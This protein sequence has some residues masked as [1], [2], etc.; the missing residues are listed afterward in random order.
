[1]EKL[2]MTISSSKTSFPIPPKFTIPDQLNLALNR[3]CY[4]RIGQVD[5]HVGSYRT[6]FNLP[7]SPQFFGNN[8][9]DNLA[10]ILTRP[11]FSI[12]SFLA[13]TAITSSFFGNCCNIY[14]SSGDGHAINDAQRLLIIANEHMPLVIG[15]CI[16]TLRIEDGNFEQL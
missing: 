11:I 2:S 15:S 14:Y 12:D 10:W 3:N 1:M 16:P 9:I 8:V 6:S 13:N 5:G 7:Q 4:M